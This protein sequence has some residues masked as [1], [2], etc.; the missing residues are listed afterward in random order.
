MLECSGIG[1]IIGTIELYCSPVCNIFRV[2]IVN[3]L[4]SSQH[5]SCV[6][7]NQKKCNTRKCY[8]VLN[9]QHIYTRHS[10]VFELRLVQI[11]T[12]C[13][14]LWGIISRVILESWQQTKISKFLMAKLSIFLFTCVAPGIKEK[15]LGSQFNCKV[16]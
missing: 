5:N 8:G 15:E 7:K 12:Y 16:W 2:F 14:C 9:L 6:N 13:W 3:H 4:K 1:V 11:C 10:Q